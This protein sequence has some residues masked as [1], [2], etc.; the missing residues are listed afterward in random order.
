[1]VGSMP[2]IL[3]LNPP[4]LLITPKGKGTAIILLDYSSEHDLVWVT[5]DDATGEIWCWPNPKVRAQSNITMGRSRAS[6]ID[7][8]IPERMF[9]SAE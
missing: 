4:I 3:Q 5:I 1:M 8:P 2:H 9:V 7:E 6:K